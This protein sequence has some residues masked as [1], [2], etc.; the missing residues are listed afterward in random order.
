LQV[1]T[2][3]RSIR[4]GEIERHGI[5]EQHKK[6]PGINSLGRECG[7]EPLQQLLQ[8]RGGDGAAVPLAGEC[9]VQE[10]AQIIV[11]LG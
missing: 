11:E 10:G 7:L 8:Q 9:G 5:E 6:R 4:V 1:E 2:D 3:V